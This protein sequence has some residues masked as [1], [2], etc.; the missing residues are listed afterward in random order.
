[1]KLKIG[2]VRAMVLISRTGPSWYVNKDGEEHHSYFRLGFTKSIATD[3]PDVYS[4]VL[5]W[6]LLIIS[7]VRKENEE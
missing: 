2:R 6:V 4:L 7:I 3:L 5:L 1:M